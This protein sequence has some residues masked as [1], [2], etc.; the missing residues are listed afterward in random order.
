MTFP[1]SRDQKIKLRQQALDWL[2]AELGAWAKLLATAKN[3]QRGGIVNTL[4][5]W[6]RDID[7]AGIRDDA[8]LAKL[9]ETERAAFRK[10]WADVDALLKKAS[11]S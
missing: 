1:P 8:E 6:Q 5:H 9:P 10:L 2:T 7:L 3:E 4:E 11:R